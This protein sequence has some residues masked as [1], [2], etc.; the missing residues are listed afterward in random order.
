MGSNEEQVARLLREYGSKPPAADLTSDEKKELAR[1]VQKNPT[2]R[3]LKDLV[4]LEGWQQSVFLLNESVEAIGD[5]KF[6]VQFA[7]TQ[8]FRDGMF[9]AMNLLEQ[10]V[11]QEESEDG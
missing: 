1:F 10:L 7:R 3:K 2:F 8:G 4:R 9:H 6:A 5:P 11:E